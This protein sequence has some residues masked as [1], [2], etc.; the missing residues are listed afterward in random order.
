MNSRGTSISNLTLSLLFGM[1]FQRFYNASSRTKAKK[2]DAEKE[3]R[4][5]QVMLVVSCNR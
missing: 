3:K 1:L 4:K 5:F 2:V